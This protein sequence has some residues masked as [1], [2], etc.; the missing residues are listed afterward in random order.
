MITI[1]LTAI[2]VILTVELGSTRSMVDASRWPSM[3]SA[4]MTLYQCCCPENPTCGGCF[5]CRKSTYGCF[6]DTCSCYD[7]IAAEQAPPRG[8]NNGEKSTQ[9][10]LIYRRIQLS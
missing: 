10:F 8:D 7:P 6:C 9:S 1:G 2:L 5:M 4:A 3:P